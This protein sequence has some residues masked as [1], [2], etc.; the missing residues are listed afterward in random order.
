[1]GAFDDLYAAND[2]YATAFVDPGLTGTA[3]RGLAVLTCI[4][5]RI[6]PLAALG[7][8]PG[9]AKSSVTPAPASPKTP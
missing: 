1:M 6:D 4:D 9:D 2:T 3:R 8:T 7:L 5:S